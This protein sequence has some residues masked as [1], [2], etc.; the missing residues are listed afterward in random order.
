[1]N[2]LA[3]VLAVEKLAGIE[4]PDTSKDDSGNDV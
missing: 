4:V 2:N 3:Y 1:M